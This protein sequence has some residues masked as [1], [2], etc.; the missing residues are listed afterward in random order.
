[1]GII[2]ST[3]IDENEKVCG[4]CLFMDKEYNSCAINKCSISG[5]WVSGGHNCDDCKNFANI[6]EEMDSVYRDGEFSVREIIEL[7]RQVI[8]FERYLSGDN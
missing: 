5:K 8:L 2:W 4:N 6:N 7:K 1:M 3:R